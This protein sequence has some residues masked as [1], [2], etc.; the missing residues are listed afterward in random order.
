MKKNKVLASKFIKWYFD[1]D[2]I[3]DLGNTV[4]TSLFETG[5]FN[6]DAQEVFDQSGYIPLGICENDDTSCEDEE[7][8]PSE[9]EFI[10]DYIK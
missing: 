1:N 5:E 9:V 7:Y 2:I 8:D 6:I 3:S 10:N 4:A